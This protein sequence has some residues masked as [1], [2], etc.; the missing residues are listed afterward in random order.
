MAAALLAVNVMPEVTKE[1]TKAIQ[2]AINP[3]VHRED[4][5]VFITCNLAKSFGNLADHY[6][7]MDDKMK[8]LTFCI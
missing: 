5:G 2:A 8:V 3:V 1:I 7:A 4:D 6:K